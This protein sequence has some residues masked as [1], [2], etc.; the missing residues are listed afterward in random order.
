M[1]T[2]TTRT[3]HTE[4]VVIG[5]G[6]AGLAAGFHLAR[7]GRR[8]VILD[9]GQRVGDSWRS[10]W[11]S[12]RLYSPANR[13]G[14][15]GMEFPGPRFAF[16]GKDEVADF[17]EAYAAKF[18]LPVRT[19]TRVRRLSHD[20]SRYVVDC[21]DT[22]I[23]AHNVIVATGTFGGTPRVPGFADD[24]DPTI[25]QLHSSDYRKPGQLR[26]GP[27]LVVGASHTG[28]DIAFE[29]AQTHDTVLC[30]RDTGQIPPRL[31]STQMRMLFPVL[32]FVWGNVL[33]VR[34]PAGR[35][36]RPMARHH[37]APF[38]RVKRADLKA[39]GVERVT[40]RMTGVTNGLPTL[41]DGRVL[42]V[43][44]V[45]WCTGFQQDFSW[46]DLP[47][48]GEDDWP[49]EQ[50]GVVPSQPGLYFTGLS[51]QSSFRSMLIGG[52]GADAEYVVRH[53]VRRRQQPPGASDRLVAA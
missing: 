45:V 26:K 39:A 47:V 40:E 53:L 25:R 43:A 22:R 14:L 13:N 46:I 28:G 17:L 44:N 24:L 6:Q 3:E 1:E 34:T 36:E 15:P 51:F 48:T 12:L 29:L 38:L 18:E 31:E 8:F 50:R 32:W 49:L 10:H 30:G 4:T 19:G 20:G 41:A 9:A 52:A 16:P 2:K 33:S 35:K 27:V 42:D 11:D 23:A 37:G 5:G 7:R 21:G